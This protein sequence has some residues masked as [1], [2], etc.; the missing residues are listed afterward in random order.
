[1]ILERAT[2]KSVTEWTQTRLWGPLGMEFDGAWCLDSSQNGFE[3]MEAGLNARA[4][5]YA[6]LGQLFLNGGR[7]NGRQIVSAEWVALASGIDPAGH[8]PQFADDEYYAYMWWG[9][10]RGGDQP[11]FTAWGDR[12][13]YVYVSPA[14]GIVIVRNG[15]DYGIDPRSWIEVFGKVAEELD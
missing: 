6:K 11:D 12:G 15:T 5:D 13:Q 10:W 8:A 7:W 3:K 1:M 9:F 4:I 14:H 2:G